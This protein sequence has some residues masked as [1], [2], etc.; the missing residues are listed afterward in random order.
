MPA[1]ASGY[2]TVGKRFL[3]VLIDCVPH[4]EAERPFGRGEVLGLNGAQ[5]FDDG[6]RSTE[7]R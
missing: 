3:D 7:A 6:G 1:L 4:P 5:P 2:R